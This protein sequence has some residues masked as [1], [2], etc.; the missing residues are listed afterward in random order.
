MVLLACVHAVAAYAAHIG[1]GVRRTLEVGMRSRM[2]TLALGVDFLGRGFGGV[3]NLRHISAAFHVCL[4]RPVTVL[5]GDPICTVHQNHL[6]VA[7]WCKI[8]CHLLMAGGAGVSAHKVCGCGA[9]AE[10]GVGLSAAAPPHALAQIIP[11]PSTNIRH[12][13]S[14]DHFPGT[15]LIGNCVTGL[16]LCIE[17]ATSCALVVS[18]ETVVP[19]SVS[20]SP[21]EFTSERPEKRMDHPPEATCSK[22]A[23]VRSIT[24][25]AA[26]YVLSVAYTVTIHHIAI[27]G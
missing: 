16:S 22:D 9:F 19:A 8:L 1:L 7:D 10:E 18:F 25:W 27:R 13:R 4:A 14:P 3:K 23:H 5:A 26:S 2:A 12:A 24:S 21:R 20:R 11:A 17:K 15:A 6:A